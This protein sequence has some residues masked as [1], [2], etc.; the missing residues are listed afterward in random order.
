VNLFEET[1]EK[2]GKD[3]NDIQQDFVSKSSSAMVVECNV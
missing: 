1:L 2:Y 3:L